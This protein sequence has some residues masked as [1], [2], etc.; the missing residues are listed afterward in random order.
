[1]QTIISIKPFLAVLASTFA[2]ILI[3]IYWNRPNIREFWSVLAG[4][5]KFGIVISMAPLVF[6]GNTIEYTLVTFY[7][8]IDI[9][10]RVDPFG[11]VFATISSFLWICTTFY[12]IGY[13]RS[14]NEHAQ[15]RYYACFA[16]TLFAAISI[17]FSAYLI[18]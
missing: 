17:A 5:I 14:T 1:M 3:L 12:S 9:K 13:M 18:T 8:G 10:F 2:T 4:V 11:L 7:Q 15:T 16:L 6:S